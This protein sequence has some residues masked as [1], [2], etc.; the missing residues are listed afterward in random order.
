MAVFLYLHTHPHLVPLFNPRSTCQS[1]SRRC[2]YLELLFLKVFWFCFLIRVMRDLKARVFRLQHLQCWNYR[3]GPQW[4]AKDFP[5]L[6][7]SFSLTAKWRMYQEL[8]RSPSAQHPASAT[9][10]IDR[11]ELLLELTHP[12]YPI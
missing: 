6:Y 11:V 1:P 9:V 4:P 3:R 5:V 12:H 2:R 10:G 7:I 8:L